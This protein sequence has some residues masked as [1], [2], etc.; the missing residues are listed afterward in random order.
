MEWKFTLTNDEL[1]RLSWLL[2]GTLIG[3]KRSTGEV[4]VSAQYKSEVEISANDQA[5]LIIY[6]LTIAD[7]ATFD[8]E[9]ETKN[10]MRWKDRIKVVIYGKKCFFI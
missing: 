8:C 1:D 4:D 7:G 9:V 6:N 2:N 5:T 3:R 10:L